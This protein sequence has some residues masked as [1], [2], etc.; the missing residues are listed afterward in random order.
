[1]LSGSLYTARKMAIAAGR[2]CDL[3]LQLNSS[4]SGKLV[5][6]PAIIFSLTN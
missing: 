5:M 6:Y 1:M 2:A 4:I 3:P